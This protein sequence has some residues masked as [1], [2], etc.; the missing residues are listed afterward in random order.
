MNRAEILD[1]VKQIICN[2][3][4]DVHGNPEDTHALIAGFWSDY[5]RTRGWS[6]DNADGMLTAQDVA[7]LM[8]LFKVARHATNPKHQDN[9]LDAIGYAAIAGELTT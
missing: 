3:R 9:L 2:D 6:V 4:Q 5:L 8:V 7:V 1:R